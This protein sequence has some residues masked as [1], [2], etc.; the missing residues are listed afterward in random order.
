MRST[1]RAAAKCPDC[2]EMKGPL[3]LR[4]WAVFSLANFAK[5][6]K[7][8]MYRHDN[9]CVHMVSLTIRESKRRCGVNETFIH[10][11]ALILFLYEVYNIGKCITS[12]KP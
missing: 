9:H 6:L 8:L 11:T 10:V 7:N 4:R 2:N 3:A 1:A 5:T 12:I